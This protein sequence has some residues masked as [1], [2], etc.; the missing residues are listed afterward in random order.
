MRVWIAVGIIWTSTLSWAQPV[1]L[2]EEPK[3]QQN[4]TVWLK[5][6]PMRDALRAISK[7]VGIPLR[8]QDAIAQE[9]VAIFVESRPAHEVLT[10]LAQL[11]RYA[12]RKDEDGSYVLFVPDE[13]RQQE[14]QLQR[15]LSE[16]RRDALRDFV[17]AA[18]ELIPL[19]PEARENRHAQLQRREQLTPYERQQLTVLE[20]L[21][22]QR[23]Y[24]Y[25]SETADMTRP[26]FTS[27]MSLVSLFAN[28]PSQAERELLNGQTVGISTRP[29]PGVHRMPPT[30]Q[31][32]TRARERSFA[33]IRNTTADDK[34]VRYAVIF[35]EQ[36]PEVWGAWLYLPSWSNLVHYQIVALVRDERRTGFESAPDGTLSPAP[37]VVRQLVQMAGAV[38]FEL[39]AYCTETPL[40]R[41][42]RAWAHPYERVHKALRPRSEPA[43]PQR[44]EP[45]Q[46]D[47]RGEQEVLNIPVATALEQIAWLTG[48]PVIADAY[49]C[50][51]ISVQL[52]NRRN[53]ERA[54][55]AVMQWM[56]L[57]H[58][59]SG[60]LLARTRSYW[61]YRRVE[62]P[63]SWLR[64]LEQKFRSGAW[65]SLEDY[66]NLA[67]KLTPAQLEAWERV[68]QWL[69]TPYA[70][71]GIEPVVQGVRALR[72]L[73]SLAPPQR[74]RLALGQ[75]LPIDQ[76]TPAQRQRFWDAFHGAARHDRFP[77]PQRLIGEALWDVLEYEVN[78]P[79]Y[80]RAY[81]HLTHAAQPPTASQLPPAPAVQIVYQPERH[82]TIHVRGSDYTWFS[83]P[84]PEASAPPTD[85]EIQRA[86][87]EQIKQAVSTVSGR[88]LWQDR[89][90]VYE[91]KLSDGRT[92]RDVLIRQERYE[93][94]QL[95]E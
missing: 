33:Q 52:V 84:H 48:T 28:L 56:W 81:Y 34:T 22:E 58:D 39:D 30:V 86:L 62:L 29:Q 12:W 18:R 59:E 64:P 63:E 25:S 71:F 8:C 36:N 43:T 24:V 74:Q 31:A 11:F 17:R 40:M 15:A 95:P 3:F 44:P 13:T 20:L 6:E 91:I 10:R 65:L 89:V 75:W 26:E 57:H 90:L 7:Q 83:L 93:P 9:K 92:T 67:A 80:R 42:W 4:I 70:E 76:L 55:R 77:E 87:W 19:T 78:M 37:S 49:R 5:L 46:P 61:D 27:D 14:A 72:F 1:N 53:L 2:T 50:T 85:A 88:R 69:W 16:A 60:Y 94:L 82:L 23:I 21:R 66:V 68:D 32:P 47:F 38:R 54:L 73:A 45:L 41:E 35:S 51:K 79:G